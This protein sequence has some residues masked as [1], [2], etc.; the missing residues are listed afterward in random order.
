MKRDAVV[1]YHAHCNDGAMAAAIFMDEVGEWYNDISYVGAGYNIGTVPDVQDK[2]VYLLDFSYPKDTIVGMLEQAH[3]VTV[4]DH[5]KD[6]LAALEGISDF[7]FNMGY[8]SI[9]QCG[10]E[11]TYRMLNSGETPRVVKLIGD[12]DMW[13]FAYSE[14]RAFTAGLAL[15]DITPENMLNVLSWTDAQ[16]DECAAKGSNILEYKQQL[17]KD[18]IK[19]CTRY[20]VI[21]GCAVP[22]CNANGAFASE[23]GE[24]MYDG[25]YRHSSFVATYYDTAE[26][27]C[28][29]LRSR[30]GSGVFV[31]GIARQ[32]GGNGHPH[33][34]GFKVPRNHVLALA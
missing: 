10:A 21:G 26:K 16:I 14:T 24:A 33:A 12:R 19:Q 28:F 31:D 15:L 13:E 17:Y 1:I 11:N 5:H 4:V 6:A 22:V 34:A 3:S 23:I 2:E 27:R 20:M 8:S 32:Y 30:R 18:H 9:S 29:S 25:I 7:K